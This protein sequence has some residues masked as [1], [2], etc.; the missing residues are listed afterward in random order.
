MSD[1]VVTAGAGIVIGATSAYFLPVLEDWL[2]PPRS[3]VG[4]WLGDHKYWRRMAQVILAIGGGVVGLV[5][6]VILVATG[7]PWWGAAGVGA[8]LGL[9]LGLFTRGSFITFI[10]G[11]AVAT[12]LIWLVRAAI[13]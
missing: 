1:I 9:A 11:G 10:G 12:V 4:G 13:S 3:S 8:G 2:W 6:G 5:I 7:W